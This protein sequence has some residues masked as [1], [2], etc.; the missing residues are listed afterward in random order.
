MQELRDQIGGVLLQR[1]IATRRRGGQP[2]LAPMQDRQ[3][4]A[5]PQL[6]PPARGGV[7]LRSVPLGTVACSATPARGPVVGCLPGAVARGQPYR[8]QGRQRRPQGWSSLGRA[9]TGGQGQLSLGRVTAC[10]Q[11]QPSPA[12]GQQRRRRGG[13]KG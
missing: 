6:R 11:G 9:T 3:P 12:Q 10:G 7:R 4:T 8:Q 13:K 2:R 5:R 1:S